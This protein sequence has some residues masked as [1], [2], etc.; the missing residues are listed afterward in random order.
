MLHNM[1]KTMRIGMVAYIG[2]SLPLAVALREAVSYTLDVCN[3]AVQRK[4]ECETQTVNVEIELYVIVGGAPD[5]R[6]TPFMGIEVHI[7]L[8]V[9]SPVN[10]Q[11]SPC[12]CTHVL[13]GWELD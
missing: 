9:T 3:G 4:G 12:T 1:P 11:C 6:I 10:V 13:S 8:D 5:M 7:S 2:D